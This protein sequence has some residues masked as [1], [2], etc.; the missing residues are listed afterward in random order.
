MG[1]SRWKALYLISISVLFALSLWF[2]AS[3]ILPELKVAWNLNSFTASWV[4]SSVQIGFIVGA[5]ISSLL[6]IPD[7]YN[8][9]KVFAISALLGALVNGLLIFVSQ[10]WLGLFIRFLTGITL[11]G[12]YPTAVKLISVRYPN[13]RGMAI[14]TLIGALTL[15]SALPHIVVTFFGDV[16][17]KG[18]I[19]TSSSLA[20]I[21]AVIMY[22]FVQGTSVTSKKTKVSI[23]LIGKVI[24]NRRVMLA[25]YG[26]FGHM[27]EL[28]AMWTWLPVFLTATF[29]VNYPQQGLLLSALWS[30]LIIG[31]AG[32]LGCVLGGYLADKIGK[33]RLTIIAMMTSAGCTLL[34]G[35][36]L[37]LSIWFTLLIALI[38]GISVIADSAQFS[39]IVSEYS[40]EEYTGTALTFQMAIG[41]IITVLS[42]NLLPIVQSHIGWDWVFILL[43]IG[44][45]LGVISMLKLKKLEAGD[46]I[47]RMD[48]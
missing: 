7:R 25:N 9:R 38:W 18:V 23:H 43:S 3:A 37:Q 30:F 32:A 31:V 21:S 24:K 11:A 15:G 26:Y 22:T 5:L 2:S 46:K 48:G 10:A 36:T 1:I 4:T 6:G 16:N 42:I 17:W 14:G 27:W 35:L 28:Y 44:P 8:S 29:R 47:A 19:I 40:S 13:Q 45:I 34:I 33:P 12:V 20:L 41:F 39:A